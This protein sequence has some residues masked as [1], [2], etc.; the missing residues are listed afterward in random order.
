MEHFPADTECE[1]LVEVGGDMVWCFGVIAE[2]RH[3]LEDGT[4]TAWVRY[5]APDGN[6]IDIF[7]S[8]RLRQPQIDWSHGRTTK[9]CG[10]PEQEHP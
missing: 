4:W 10:S 2:W 3:N 6:R 5:S 8:H 1:V 9:S 7:P